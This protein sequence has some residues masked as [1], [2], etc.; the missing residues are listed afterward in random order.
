MFQTKSMEGSKTHP[1]KSTFFNF[2]FKSDFF[3]LINP[4]LLNV[5]RKVILHNR[6]I[7]KNE[8][9]ICL[10]EFETLFLNEC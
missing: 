6:E 8:S 9:H 5:E 4:N 2:L 10:N 1:K 7:N 3:P